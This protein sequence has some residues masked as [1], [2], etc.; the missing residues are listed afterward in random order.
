MI[1]PQFLKAKKVAVMGLGVTGLSICEALRQAD[2]QL[3][4][5]DD[6]EEA[7]TR[8]AQNGIPL[9]NL[10]EADFSAID[11]L[12]WS[13]G[14]P[15]YYPETHPLIQKANAHKTRIATDIDV[16]ALSQPKARYVCITGTNG[17]STTTALIHHILEQSGMKTSCGGN[18]GTAALTLEPLDAD[19]VYVLE[20]SS[21]QLEMSQFL[22]SDISILLNITEDHL[23]H[24]GTMAD[25][26]KAKAKLFELT[27]KEGTAIIGIEEPETKV[28][29]DRFS[30]SGQIQNVHALCVNQVYEGFPRMRDGWLCDE[31]SNQEP[32]SSD[33]N[34]MSAL[35]GA[36]NHQNALAAYIA[37]RAIGLSAFEVISHIRSFPG[38]HHRQQLV[39]KINRIEIINDSKAT[40]PDAASKALSCYDSIFWLIGGVPKSDQSS[41]FDCFNP[42]LSKI[43]KAYL[44]G[45][46]AGLFEP[47]LNKKLTVER[48]E[49][50]DEAFFKASQDAIESGVEGGTI[51][52]SPACASFDQF[53]NF[54]HRG[55]YF[56]NLVEQHFSGQKQVGV[57]YD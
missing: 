2:A 47:W 14:I 31:L 27:K 55:D 17:K 46:S 49:T 12:L 35:R 26:V 39:T 54:E 13:P 18:L 11:Y 7:R 20:L 45:E 40:N 19:G 25:Y 5:W 1:V 50:L 32:F 8:A 9:V 36:H 30:Q 57:I 41:S 34:E 29:Y 51:L 22:K 24:H 28:I 16:L 6:Q 10:Y 48:F 4:A 44:Y 21:Y 37:C 33:F 53:K 52:L 43:K 15:A 3:M 38:L 56:M 42:F 23:S